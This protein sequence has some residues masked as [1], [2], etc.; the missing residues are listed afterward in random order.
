MGVKKVLDVRGLA[1]PIPIVKAKKAIL[2][3]P[4]RKLKEDKMGVLYIVYDGVLP[5][6]ERH[7][8]IMRG[9]N[10]YFHRD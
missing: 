9:L 8:K 10:I 1:C 2:K 4:S 6:I 7:E 5:L 3:C